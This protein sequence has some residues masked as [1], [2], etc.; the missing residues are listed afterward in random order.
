VPDRGGATGN[1][2]TPLRVALVSR[3]RQNPYVS[4]L[5]K[6]LSQAA[7]IDP[8]ESDRFSVGWVWG[9]RRD[10]DVIHMHWLELFVV[11]SSWTRSVKRLASVILGLVAARALGI[12][13]VYTVHNVH[14]HEGRRRF[15]VMVAN[16]CMFALANAVH[17]H[18]P[19]TGRAI[20][21]SWRRS[22]R[23]HVIAHGNYVGAYPN[24]VSRSAARMTLGIPD[25]A[26]VL[27]CLGRL[28][29][30]KGVED[31]LQAFRE[32]SDPRALLL[33]AGEAQEPGY[34][35]HLEEQAT[36][37]RVRLLAKYVADE[38]LQLY[39]NASDV[40]VLPY[41]HVTTSGAAILSFSFGVPIIAPRLGCFE[42]L[43][44][45]GERGYLYNTAGSEGL[46]W[47]LRTASQAD[48]VAMRQ[49]CLRYVATLDWATVAQKHAD[50][51]RSIRL[52]E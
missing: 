15:L 22:R 41:R 46:L 17:V 3:V 21:R 24:D 29:P 13:I 12:S 45:E 37:S 6:G 27:L 7:G 31:L 48:L 51:Y 42:A 1:C 34:I 36:D 11:Y 44:G 52:C 19:D 26:L 43:V 33:I 5:C 39:L 25:D 10:V 23:V 8:S 49:S 4:L 20:R 32:V 16:T 14:Q 18:N 47:A 2:S 50:V 40:S 30:Y 35:S 9:H 38:D 28:R